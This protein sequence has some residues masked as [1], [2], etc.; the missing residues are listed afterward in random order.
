MRIGNEEIL[1]PTTMV[2]NYPNPRWY[3]GQAFATVPKG[4]FIFD[5]ISREAFEDAVGAIVHDQEAAGFDVIADGKVY[6]GDS[7]YGTILYYYSERMSGWRLSGPPV[8]LPIYSTLYSPTCVGEINREHPFH[9]AH[10][11]AVRKAT[12][13][14]VKISYTGL[15]VIAAATQNLHYKDTKEL[16]MALAKAFNEDFKELADNGCEIIQL[17]EFVWPYGMGD[18]EIEA[19]NASVEGVDCQ[20]WVHTCW[21]NYSGTPAYFP[22]ETS[23]EFGAYDFASRAKNAP[24][25]ERAHAIFPHV[26]DANI[27]ALNY[28]VGRTGVD[29]LTPLKDNNWDKDF[30]AGVID[31][32]STITESAEEVAERIREV[33]KVVP[34]ER[35]GLSTDCGLINLPRMFGQSKLKALVAGR[36]IVR[37]ELGG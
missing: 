31:V 8:G 17:D 34:A 10:L 21:G 29:D 7:P 18:W 36:D 22:D 4:E 14:P 27:H 16:A 32:K 6:G 1:L 23:T 33:L 25:P 3:D 35:L 20:F 26:L 13:K 24:A 9:L 12:K 19:L 37:G 5:A 11:R 28:E 30:V 15:G 2:G